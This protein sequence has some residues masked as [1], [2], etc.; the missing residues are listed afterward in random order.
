MLWGGVYLDTDYRLLKPLDEYLDS[1]G[2]LGFEREGSV[3]S[4]IMG[5]EKGHWLTKEIMEYYQNTHF[6]FPNGQLNMLPNTTV[7]TDILKKH[8]MNGQASFKMDD[9][10]VEKS[11]VFYGSPDDAESYG[12]HYFRG[13]WWSE[14]ERKR[15]N[16]KVY[17]KI[18][19]PVL[20]GGRGVLLH[21]LGRL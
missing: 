6:R 10:V 19:R 1:G 5:F 2:F 11:N 17:T 16:S 15:S 12:I 20:R 8:G 21:M 14:K 7:I 3:G 13:S 18:V 4:A 9:L